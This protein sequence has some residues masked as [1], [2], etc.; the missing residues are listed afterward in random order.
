MKIQM[1]SRSPLNR[2]YCL[3]TGLS[4]RHCYSTAGPNCR[5]I[6][7]HSAE[8]D[9]RNSFVP[10][11]GR[12]CR[13]SPKRAF[14][15][16]SCPRMIRKAYQKAAGQL[17]LARADGETP[18]PV[19]GLQLNELDRDQFEK[20]VQEESIFGQLTPRQKGD[21]VRELRHQGE[22]VAVVGDNLGDVLAMEEANLRISHRSSSQATVS[23]ADI[24]LMG[25]SFEVLP[26]VLQRG[27]RLVNGLLD[28]LKI[29]LVR[30]GYVLLLIIA[31]LM[32][33]K[34][35][36]FYAPAQGGAITF[37]T[38]A[39][40]SLGL[41]LWSSAGALPRQYMRS[42]L[43]HFVVPAVLTVTAAVLAT[44]WIFGRGKQRIQFLANGSHSSISPPSDCFSLSSSSRLQGSGLVGIYSAAT[45]VARSW[46]YCSCSCSWPLASFP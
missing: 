25:D 35:A 6:L 46:R 33:G 15:S 10:K 16:R 1:K 9:L 43:W 20:N 23:A 14:V 7:F 5:L 34:R 19:S 2:N 21:I 24:I 30:I 38:V 13:H 26:T 22:R 12:L 29:N 39:I 45:S 44:N 27:Q 4:Q 3:P 18:I 37:F 11:P 36:F 40:P 8:S 17:G 32:A 41:T 28:I 31:M 42:R